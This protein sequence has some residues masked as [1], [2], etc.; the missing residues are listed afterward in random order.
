MGIFVSICVKSVVRSYVRLNRLSI[1]AYL[2]PVATCLTESTIVVKHFPRFLGKEAHAANEIDRW[3]SVKH[4]TYA[5]V[6]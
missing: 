3:A 5:G 4:Q 2:G 6:V 1:Y